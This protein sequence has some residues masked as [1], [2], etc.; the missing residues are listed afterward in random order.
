MSG[1]L[2]KRSTKVLFGTRQ[3]DE[4]LGRKIK[5]TDSGS[6]PSSRW[7]RICERIFAI[8]TLNDVNEIAKTFLLGRS[9]KLNESDSVSID[10]RLAPRM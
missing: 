10:R 1:L 8:W 6:A 9:L 2:L 3:S 5:E 7:W 4:V